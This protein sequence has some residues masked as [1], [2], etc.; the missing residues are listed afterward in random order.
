MQSQLSESPIKHVELKTWGGRDVNITAKNVR[1]LL[2]AVVLK[3]V[4]KNIKG[5]GMPDLISAPAMAREAGIE[6]VIS[7]VR[8]MLKYLDVIVQKWPL[9]SCID[10]FTVVYI[11]F[12]APDM[13]IV[14]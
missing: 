8:F 7:Q 1:N 4:V 3:G 9:R 11:L 6:S 14:N 12:M 5:M 13:Y 2:E 10:A